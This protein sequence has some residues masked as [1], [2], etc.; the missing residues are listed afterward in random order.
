[1]LLI[2]VHLGK[3]TQTGALDHVGASGHRKAQGVLDA[4]GGV[5][6]HGQ[7]GSERGIAGAHSRQ[8]LDVEGAVGKPD[9]LA[10]GEVRTGATKGQQHVLGALGVQLGHSALDGLVATTAHL[11]AKDVKQL[12]V[13]GLDQQWLQSNEVCQLMA[14]DVEDELGPL[15]LDT[16]QD[17]GQEALG[18]VGRQRAADDQAGHVIERIDKFKH[19][20]LVGLIDGGTGIDHVVLGVG[21]GVEEH[22]DARNTVGPHGLDGHAQGLGALNDKLTREAGEETQDRGVD[23]IVVKRKRDVEALAV[24]RVDGIAGTRDGIGSKAVAGD[25]VVNG[26]ICSERVNHECSFHEATC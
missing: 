4:L 9:M 10:V 2:F 12:V 3:I 7:E 5:V 16:A 1:M 13:I 17:L 20:L 25:V 19:L 14:R 22:I 21:T 11:D 15:G 6:P 26:G 8:Q 24:G 23:T 18:S